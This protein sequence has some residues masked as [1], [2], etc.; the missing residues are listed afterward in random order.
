MSKLKVLSN[1]TLVDH[2][3]DAPPMDSEFVDTPIAILDEPARDDIDYSVFADAVVQQIR[4]VFDPE[5]P[6][7]IYD[8]GLIYAIDLKSTETGMSAHVR[9]TLTSPGCPV[10]GT[11]PGEVQKKILQAQ[12]ISK[13]TVELVWQPTWSRARMSEAALLECGLM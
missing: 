1:R 2:I 5:L 13:A 7:N 10:A 9:M 3:R 12:G 8:L 6:V 4:T 11:L